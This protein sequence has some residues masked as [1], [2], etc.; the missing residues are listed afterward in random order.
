MGSLAL[1]AGDA[2][3]ATTHFARAVKLA[4]RPEL[5]FNLGMARLAGGDEA[6][7]LAELVTAVKLN[8][9]VV[10][11]VTSPDLLAR[12]RTVLEAEGYTARHPWL[13]GADPWPRR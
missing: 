12:L 7:G 11:Q 10:K 2:T 5:R 1:E 13:F 4:E 9:A 8:P 6:G 3:V